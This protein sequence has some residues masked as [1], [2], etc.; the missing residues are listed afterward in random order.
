M[1][2][3]LTLILLASVGCGTGGGNTNPDDVV[4]EPVPQCDLVESE[5][6]NDTFSA[7][8][9]G[10]I[11]PGKGPFTFCGTINQEFGLFEEPFDSNDLVKWG[12]NSELDLSFLLTAD[13]GDPYVRLFVQ[14]L[15]P[16]TGLPDQWFLGSFFGYNGV[17][18]VEDFHIY[19]N[20]P[21]LAEGIYLDIGTLN[22]EFNY[23]LEFWVH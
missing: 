15:D 20:D 8:F 17:L 9:L 23:T 1:K 22:E 11:L 3:L 2:K 16:E 6:N 13:T 10:F 12:T 4:S 7:N 21:W 18:F 19:W 14:E 5:P